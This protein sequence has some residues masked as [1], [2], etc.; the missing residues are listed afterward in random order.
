M[1]LPRYM[2]IYLVF[3]HLINIIFTRYDTNENFKKIT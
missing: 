2:H 3:V 1:S